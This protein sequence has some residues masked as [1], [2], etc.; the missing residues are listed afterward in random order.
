MS[1]QAPSEHVRTWLEKLPVQHKPIVM[2]LRTLMG[3]VAPDAHEIIYHDALGYG[4]TDAG[5]DRIVYI[6]VFSAHIN[7]GF[8]YGGFL[9][10]PERLLVGSGK[11]MRH[12]K[13]RSTQE[14]AN[15]ALASLLEQAW[16]DGLQRVSRR[17]HV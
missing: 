1:I 8:F 11:R 6:A 17:H 10:D 12:I 3:T 7:V 14:C 2:A 15:P 13:I 4:P 5:F 16:L 9:H